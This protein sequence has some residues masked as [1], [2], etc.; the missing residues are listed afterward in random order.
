MRPVA[1]GSLAI[2][3]FA[4][5]SATGTLA[6]DP[7]S[8]AN[9]PTGNRTYHI[10]K[11]LPL[12]ANC[13]QPAAQELVKAG[14]PEKFGYEEW[15][16]VVLTN[17][18]HG[19]VGVYNILGAK[20]GVRA[21]EILSAPPRSVNVIVET[22]IKPPVSCLIDGLQV[23]LSSTVAQDL[24]HALACEA[25]RVAAVFEYKN[26]KIRLSLKPEAEKRV[27]EL[28][29]KAIKDC[30]NLTPAYFQQIEADSYQVWAEF[31]RNA[32]FDEET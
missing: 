20:M 11:T 3:L 26:R 15:A 12:Y 13:Y 29:A 19:H 24:I 18:I 5:V 10:L 30:G 32:I 1:A 14:I 31:D 17:E 22:G 21:K 28:I 16:A 7:A 2:G 8:D 25:P 4:L 6:H 23:A 27:A 9:L